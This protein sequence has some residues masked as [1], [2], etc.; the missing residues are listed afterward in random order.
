M[1]RHGK[2]CCDKLCRFPVEKEHFMQ[3]TPMKK[4]LVLQSFFKCTQKRARQR[5]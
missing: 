2:H 4:V 3:F 1:P 5:E